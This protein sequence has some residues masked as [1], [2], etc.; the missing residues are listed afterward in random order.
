MPVVERHVET[1]VDGS[2]RGAQRQLRS[3]DE[4]LGPLDRLVVDLVGGMDLV[5]ESDRERL[6]R[7]DEAAREDQVLGLRGADQSSEA[8]RTACTGNDAEQD[9]GLTELGI[10]GGES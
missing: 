1:L 2:L 5:D 9:L 3:A 10:V 4:L 8:L 6:V 7:V